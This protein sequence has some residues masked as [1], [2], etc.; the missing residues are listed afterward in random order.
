MVHIDQHQ[1]VPEREDLKVFSPTGD[2]QDNDLIDCYKITDPSFPICSFQAQFI[3]YGSLVYKFNSEDLLAEEI[4]KID[5]E[6]IH[7]SVVFYKEDKQRKKMRE[8]GKLKP[9]KPDSPVVPEPLPPVQEE[10]IIPTPIPEPTPEIIP[11]KPVVIPNE[12]VVPTPPSITPE[13]TP[14]V[15]D[16]GSDIPS[17]EDR[18]KLYKYLPKE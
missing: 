12:E 13:A 18:K 11:E 3:K 8:E 6:S 2:Y 9:E 14:D 17:V 1:A 7:D 15:I 16:Y 10:E 4:M 5:P